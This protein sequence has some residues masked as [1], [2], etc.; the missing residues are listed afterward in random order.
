MVKSVKKKVEGKSN[1]EKKFLNLYKKILKINMN[2]ITN[3]NTTEREQA[4][5]SPIDEIMELAKLPPEV[6]ELECHKFLV[7][8]M[9]GHLAAFGRK[10]GVEAT[11]T[12]FDWWYKNRIV[13]P[14]WKYALNIK[15]RDDD[16]GEI[17]SFG[18]ED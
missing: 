12:R 18:P 5:E 16:T 3:L 6:L 14:T 15:L 17:I 7:L 11:R 10:L 2:P 1:F 13:D 4:V 8:F 9:V